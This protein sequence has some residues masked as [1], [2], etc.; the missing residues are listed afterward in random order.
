MAVLVRFQPSQPYNRTD[1]DFIMR[2]NT[3]WLFNLVV[4]AAILL[5]VLTSGGCS[6]RNVIC[7]GIHAVGGSIAG[8]TCRDM[9]K[10]NR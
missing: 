2:V 9:V 1:G 10:D 3:L 8:E 5:V 6:K 7:S 4:A